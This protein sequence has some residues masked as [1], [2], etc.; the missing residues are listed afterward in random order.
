MKSMGTRFLLPFNFQAVTNAQAPSPAL[1]QSVLII[2]ATL[3]REATHRYRLPL[4]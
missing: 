2:V 4:C 3:Q 1:L